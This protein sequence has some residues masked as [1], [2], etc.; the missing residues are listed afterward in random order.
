MTATPP[1]TDMPIIEPVLRLE[2]LLVPL[3]DD[4]A[5]AE[6]LDAGLDDSVSVKVCVPATE[7]VGGLL[8]D[9]VAGALDEED[10]SVVAGAVVV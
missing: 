7:V 1:A 6:V 4:E 10:P 2:P 3:V 8:G 5:A 9:E